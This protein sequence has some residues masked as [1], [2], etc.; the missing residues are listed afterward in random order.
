MRLPSSDL[1]LLVIACGVASLIALVYKIYYISYYKHGAHASKAAALVSL[2]LFFLSF[3]YPVLLV[4]DISIISD[5]KHL[6]G[7]WQEWVTQESVKNIESVISYCYLGLYSLILFLTTAAFPFVYFSFGQVDSDGVWN[8]NKKN[9]CKGLRYLLLTLPVPIAML[10]VGAVFSG[11]VRS[12]IGDNE[13]ISLQAS[14]LNISSS[15]VVVYVEKSLVFAVNCLS[16]VGLLVALL[17]ATYGLSL[18]PIRMITGRPRG[19]LSYETSRSLVDLTTNIHKYT[20]KIQYGH[21]LSDVERNEFAQ[22]SYEL[23]HFTNNSLVGALIA[24]RQSM[25]SSI[26]RPVQ[27][28]FGVLMHAFSY[29]LVTALFLGS[30]YRIQSSFGIS[31]GYVIQTDDT[32]SN[33]FD[34]ILTWSQSR[35]PLA[36]VIVVVVV[37]V[38]VSTSTFAI[39]N[40]GVRFFCYKFDIILRG[41]TSSRSLLYTSLLLAYINLYSVQLLETV[42]PQFVLYGTQSY[43]NQTSLSNITITPPTRYDEP[44]QCSSLAAPDEC[45]LSRYSALNLRML[46]YFPFFGII[47]TYSPFVFILCFVAGLVRSIIKRGERNVTSLPT[48]GQPSSDTSASS[49]KSGFN[50]RSDSVEPLLVNWLEADASGGDHWSAA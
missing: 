7:A 24:D 47:R 50:E 27:V 32:M 45:I 36:F 49:H 11:S 48:F 5:F 2:L 18:L 41:N 43:L 28:L 33:P 38:L 19:H 15:P 25:C 35:Y 16:L 23:N 44:I 26:I 17:Y 14:Y 6:N 40:I 42:A 4:V 1:L 3:L 10:A 13:M 22:Y 46:R 29:L 8:P 21:V 12:S 31:S 20:H 30:W 34:V 9:L 37:M 39:Q